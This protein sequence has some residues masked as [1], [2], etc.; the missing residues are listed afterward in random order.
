MWCI[1]LGGSMTH[2]T[3]GASWQSMSRAPS[4]WSSETMKLKPT[5]DRHS[6]QRVIVS[7]VFSSAFFPNH[8]KY[9]TRRRAPLW[10]V[11]TSWGGP[12]VLRPRGIIIPSNLCGITVTQS[13]P[14]YWFLCVCL[15]VRSIT[16]RDVWGCGPHWWSRAWTW[17]EISE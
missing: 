17:Q 13:V 9:T 3:L 10:L 5:S 15:G 7:V 4:V 11:S 1:K 6:P 14:K 8:A 2:L 16:E 12:R